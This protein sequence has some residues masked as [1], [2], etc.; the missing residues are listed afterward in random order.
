MNLTNLEDLPFEINK[1]TRVKIVDLQKDILS[2]IHRDP[3]GENT[4]SINIPRNK[5]WKKANIS[6]GSKINLML[7][8][9]P[10]AKKIQL[11]FS[12]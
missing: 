10:V 9:S 11:T 7:T 12:Y 8:T 2:F 3:S 6:K 1:E 5:I 4:Y